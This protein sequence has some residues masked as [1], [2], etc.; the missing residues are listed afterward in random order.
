MYT[1]VMLDTVDEAG[2][3][4][5]TAPIGRYRARDLLRVPSLL[6]LSR[7]PLAACFPFVV[8]GRLR[9]LHASLRPASAMCSTVGTRVASGR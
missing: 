2:A 7:L 9:R 5:G 3:S 1:S 4:A 8:D 6:S